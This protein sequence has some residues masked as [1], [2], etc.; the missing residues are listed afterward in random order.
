LRICIS[1]DSEGQVT[2]KQAKFHEGIGYPNPDRPIL[3]VPWFSYYPVRFTW[4]ELYDRD[5]WKRSEDKLEIL[6]SI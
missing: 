2:K 5:Y 3:T 6:P 4:W 1:I